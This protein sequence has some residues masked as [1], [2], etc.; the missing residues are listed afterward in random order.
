MFYIAAEYK[1][2]FIPDAEMILLPM[3]VIASATMSLV[4]LPITNTLLPMT[5]AVIDP[6]TGTIAVRIAY[7]NSTS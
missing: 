1:Y 3:I 6:E 2:M 4:L 7:S 5:K